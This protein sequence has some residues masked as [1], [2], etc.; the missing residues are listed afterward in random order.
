MGTKKQNSVEA[1]PYETELLVSQYCEFHYGREYFDVPNFPARCARLCIEF[2]KDRKKGRALDAG[3]A[4]GRSTF[5]LARD[6]SH[7]TGV[8]F[9]DRFIRIARLARE[10]GLISYRMVIEGDLF[11]SVERG[12]A[13]VG[14]DGARVRADFIRADAMALPE[15]LTGYDLIFAGNLIDRLP[16]PRRFLSSIHQRLNPGGLLVLTSPCTWLT[17]FTPREEWLGGFSA[18]GT[19]VFTQDGLEKVLAPRLRLAAEPLDVPFVI[20]ETA[21]K[22]QHT[23]A[24][25][26]VWERGESAFFF[27]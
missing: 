13:D 24:R 15:E 3:C 18:D 10:T 23:I 12:L 27:T 16:S 1:N 6:F 17:E 7:V 19:D 9:S 4:V 20:R 25:M 2:M 22:Y 8:D 26:T 5:E 11:E 14:L 21:R